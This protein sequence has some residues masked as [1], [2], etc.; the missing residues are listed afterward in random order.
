[1]PSTE[2]LKKWAFIQDAM[3][4]HFITGGA[5]FADT[6]RMH[7][8]SATMLRHAAELM[9]EDREMNFDWL[10]KPETPTCPK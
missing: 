10:H 3:A 7:R 1:M 9:P 6:A 5:G 8:Y 4:D 2:E